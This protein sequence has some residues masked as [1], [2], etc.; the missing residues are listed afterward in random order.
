MVPLTMAVAGITRRQLF[1]NA[2]PEPHTI[3]PL[4]AILRRATDSIGRYE[5][6]DQ[7]NRAIAHARVR[8]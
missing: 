3:T 8:R 2:A 7:P 6:D 4:A 1:D 5:R